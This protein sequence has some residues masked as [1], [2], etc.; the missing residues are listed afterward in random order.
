MRENIRSAM[1]RQSSNQ[2]Q[3]GAQVSRRG[4]L[5]TFA[6]VW[7]AVAGGIGFTIYRRWRESK[8]TS[9]VVGNANELAPNSAATFHLAGRPGL[10]IRVPS[11]DYR[12]FSAECTHMN[13]TVRFLPTMDKILCPCH[14]GS[15]DLNGRVLGGPP[16]RPL[17]RYKVDIT[18]AEIVVSL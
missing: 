1:P 13:C 11:G 8:E 16:P 7:T 9:T 15:Y 2:K 5:A 6:A 17:R 18:S 12:A 14:G 3:N 10:L 4:F